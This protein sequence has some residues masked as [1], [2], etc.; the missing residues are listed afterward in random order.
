[1]LVAFA[2][3]PLTQCSNGGS[4]DYTQADLAGSWFLTSLYAGPQ[5]A[6]GT[7][8]A[9]MRGRISVDSSG[10]ASVVWTED[11][12]G[13]SPNPPV[14]IQYAVDG[15]GM[16]TAPAFLSF[17]GKMSPAKD[18][19]ASTLS[20]FPSAS[21]PSLR[22][23]QKVVPGTTFAAVD[24]A[25]A[26]FDYHILRVGADVGWEHGT[27]ST[28]AVRVLS[29]VNRST[30]TGIAPDLSNMA[31]LSVD[32]EGVV[33]APESPVLKGFLSADKAL[34]VLT[35]PISQS[36]PIHALVVATRRSGNYGPADLGGGWGLS[37]FVA[38]S[39]G[40]AGWGRGPL[41]V[42]GSGRLTFSSWLDSLGDTTV[43]DPVTLSVDPAG[44]VTMLAQPVS[45][46]HGNMAPGKKLIVATA[47]EDVGVWS[48]YL[49][50]R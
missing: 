12:A 33:T 23:Y 25:S 35:M 3:L 32:A 19:I 38:G 5:V 46:F 36:P 8:T 1:L 31:T 17:S 22:I 43:P 4:S 45:E 13:G 14:S 48:I 30:S 29:L 39:S 27:A 21:R 34:L 37:G 49:I 26:T 24:L 20:N 40:E 16:V 7:A 28:D 47:T 44:V 11:S 41:S 50:V 2:A 6:S 9:W 15:S 42:N 18:L 10:V